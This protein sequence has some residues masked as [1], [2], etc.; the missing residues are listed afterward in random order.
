MIDRYFLNI[1]TSCYQRYSLTCK[2]FTNK[3][4]EFNVS[5]SRDTEINI[6]TSVL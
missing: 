6:K 2:K 5:I 4:S 1:Q 3:K